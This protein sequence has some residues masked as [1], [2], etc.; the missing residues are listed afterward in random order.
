VRSSDVRKLIL[1]EHADLRRRLDEIEPL[2]LRFEKGD[3]AAGADLRERALALYE[4]FSAHLELEERSLVPVL[5]EA[6][7]DGERRAEHLAHE[8]HEQRELLRYLVGRLGAQPRP[9]LLVA[10]EL[11]SFAEYLRLDMRHEEET[12]LTADAFGSDAA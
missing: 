5:R 6:G 9:T 8:H 7:H 12:L 11:S 1:E 2:T 4:R 3:A 10:R